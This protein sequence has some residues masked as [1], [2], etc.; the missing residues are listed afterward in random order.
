MP[1]P[2]CRGGRQRLQMG[3]LVK[4]FGVHRVR[5]CCLSLRAVCLLGGR[6]CAGSKPGAEQGL[7]E[8]GWDPEGFDSAD[9]PVRRH[10]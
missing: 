5:A 4:G 9:V 10:G 2:E 3:L 8:W 7:Q 6:E 1:T